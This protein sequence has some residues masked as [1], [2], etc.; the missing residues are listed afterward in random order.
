MSVSDQNS[1]IQKAFET[2]FEK[3]FETKGKEKEKKE[4][5]PLS[6]LARRPKPS[7]SSLPQF[8]VHLPFFVQGRNPPSPFPSSAQRGRGPGDNPLRPALSHF[9]SPDREA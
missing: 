9:R 5:L 8:L 1:M 7:Q 6:V 4:T 2:E 3:G